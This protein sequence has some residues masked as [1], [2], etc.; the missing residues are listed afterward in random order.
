MDE[1]LVNA[2]WNMKIVVLPTRTTANFLGKLLTV[3]RQNWNNDW[4]GNPQPP[5]TQGSVDALGVIQ[6]GRA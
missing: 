3:Y 2:C 4:F 6:N 1:F 5:K